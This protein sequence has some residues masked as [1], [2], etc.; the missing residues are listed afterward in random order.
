MKI[1]VIGRCIYLCPH[2]AKIGGEFYWI[3]K[4]RKEYRIKHRGK[5]M[6]HHCKKEVSDIILPTEEGNMI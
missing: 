2:I 3:Y 4:L 6:C 5:V 1:K